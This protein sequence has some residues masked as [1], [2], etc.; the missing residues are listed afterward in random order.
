MHEETTKRTQNLTALVIA[1]VNKGVLI[2]E[3]VAI[4][5]G[6]IVYYEWPIGR[7]RTIVM[8]VRDDGHWISGGWPDQTTL[9]IHFR[10][11]T[12]SLTFYAS[13][14][15]TRFTSSNAPPLP[16]GLNKRTAPQNGWYRFWKDK[17][18]IPTVT[19]TLEELVAT[20]A[21]YL[22]WATLREP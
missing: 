18:N 7:N 17:L 3:R 15:D 14:D 8:S 19:L 1:L 9:A 22:N 6:G 16:R 21:W 2:G 4:N 10:D 13:R 11:P 20:I 5:E 12:W